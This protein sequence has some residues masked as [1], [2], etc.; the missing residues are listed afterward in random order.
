MNEYTEDSYLKYRKDIFDKFQQKNNSRYGAKVRV[1]DKKKVLEY[2]RK[3]KAEGF[4]NPNSTDIKALDNVKNVVAYICKYVS[5]KSEK[6]VEG[7]IWGSSANLKKLSAALQDCSNEELEEIVEKNGE[8]IKAIYRGDFSFCIVLQRGYTVL[9]LEMPQRFKNE[10]WIRI[11]ENFCKILGK[12][13]VV[14]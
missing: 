14:T 9:D 3:S 2:F 6:K 4:C 10:Y 11:E 1:F 5:K 7:R 8:K 13:L 12:N